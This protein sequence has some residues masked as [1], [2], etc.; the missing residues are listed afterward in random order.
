MTMTIKTYL[1]RPRFGICDETFSLAEIVISVVAALVLMAVAGLM[2][3][4]DS[5]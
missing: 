4:L 5:L 1:T 2:D 3:K